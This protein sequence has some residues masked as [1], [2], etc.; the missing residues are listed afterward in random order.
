[1]LFFGGG[2]RLD[3]A[4]LAAA[5][6]IVGPAQTSPVAGGQRLGA[7]HGVIRLVELS[8]ELGFNVMFSPRGQL[9]LIQTWAK[10]RDVKRRQSTM[11]LAGVPFEILTPHEARARVHAQAAGDPRPGQ[12]HAHSPRSTSGYARMEYTPGTTFWLGMKVHFPSDPKV[13][14]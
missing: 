11:R 13:M 14:P 3:L 8:G 4:D 7:L 9:D 6:G 1:M 12:I 2:Q 5:V 10:L